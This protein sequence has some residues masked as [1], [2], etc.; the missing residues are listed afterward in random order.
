MDIGGYDIGQVFHIGARGPLWRT[1][2]NAGE[3]LIALRSADD[4]RRCLPRWK[5]WARVSSH[6]VVAL[7][8]V[9]Q[10]DDGRWAIVYDYVHGRP[11]DVEIGSADLRPKATRRQIVEG[12]AAGLGALHAAG[13]V[14]G[15][16]TP[17]NIMV[18]PQGRAVIIDLIDEIGE[19][20]GTPGWSVD[21]VGMEGDRQCL[22]RIASLLEM[23]EVLAQ[24][25]YDDVAAAV[26][27]GATPV[28]ADPEEHVIAREP[29]DPEQVI[30]DLRAAALREDTAIEDEEHTR[31][32]RR[33]TH[34]GDMGPTETRGRTR[35]RAALV[36]GIAVL[37][38]ALG[39][40]GYAGWRALTSTARPSEGEGIQ[41]QSQPPADPCDVSAVTDLINHAIEVRDQ[42]VIAGDAS[43]LD[44]VLGGELLDQ[45][46]QRIESMRSGGVR[47]EA[48]VSRVDDVSVVACEPGAIDVSATLSVLES[49]TCVEQT[50]DQHGAPNSA[51]LTL[52]VD[53]VSGKVVA[54]TAPPSPDSEHAE[55][56]REE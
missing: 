22:R 45:D 49:R 29:V 51:T 43:G 14:H 55:S 42:A 28:L 37:I 35:T 32:T 2:T 4:G 25:G 21:S 38:L 27:S 15:D 53:P 11:L 44:A 1:R 47:V 17:A 5:A 52:R 36:G 9:V 33:R 23:D 7:R 3:A 8:D 16:L 56:G 31:R 50:C 26:A 46:T 12:I 41:S 10:S 30:A 19:G 6:H 54:A 40:G 18:T 20:E 34:A 48:L 13:I 39:V 24:L